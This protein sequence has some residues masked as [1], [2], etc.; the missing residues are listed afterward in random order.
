MKKLSGVIF[1]MDGLI[2]DTEM[3]YYKATQKVADDL[4]FAYSKEVY[5][6]FLGVSDEEVWENYH[7]IY[8][9][10]GTEAV[11]KFINESHAEVLRM[12]EKGEA[13]L[14]P[15]VHQL[16]DYLNE[17]KIP[18][19][20]ASSNQRHVIELLLENAEL[21]DEFIDIV[22]SEDVK[23]A[24][25]DPEIFEVAVKRLNT[26]KEETLVLEDSQNGVLAAHKAG[27][28]VIMVPDLLVPTDDLLAKTLHVLDSLEKVPDYF[29]D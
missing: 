21:K 14:K 13:A 26:A 4:G 16:M 3:L 18:K 9:D 10:K 11:D 29:G 5:L 28:P 25:P 1:D 19:I 7:Q 20:V 8:A 23:R 27:I 15:G 12:F 2:F 17:R 22:S 24:K 6:D